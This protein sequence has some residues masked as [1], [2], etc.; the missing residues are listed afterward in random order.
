MGADV[1]RFIDVHTGD[2]A[3]ALAELRSGRKRS[4]WMWYVFPQVVGLG[5]SPMAQRYAIASVEEARASLDHPRL[6]QT[7]GEAVAAVRE[8]V[9]GG[10]GTISDLFG[11]PD[12]AKLISSLTLFRRVA[13]GDRDAVLRSD[14]DAVLAV[15]ASQGFAPCSVTTAFLATA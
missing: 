11:S 10:G 12:D 4:H 7:Y 2:V 15:A 9:V 8:Q 13:D 14:I 6:R 1:S 3:Q 5:R